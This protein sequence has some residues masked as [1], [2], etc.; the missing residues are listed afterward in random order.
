MTENLGLCLVT[1]GIAL[2]RFHAVF[3]KGEHMNVF[4]SL[5]TVEQGYGLL[6]GP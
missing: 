4:L 5:P 1:Q 6:T 3:V 2:T